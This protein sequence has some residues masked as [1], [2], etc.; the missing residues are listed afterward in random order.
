MRRTAIFG[1]LLGDIVGL[2][3]CDGDAF[4]R[5]AEIFGSLAARQ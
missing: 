4:C 5:S 3:R 2:F 1:C